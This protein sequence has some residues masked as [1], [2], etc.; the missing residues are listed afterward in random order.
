MKSWKLTLSQLCRIHNN[1]TNDRL[2]NRFFV[3]IFGMIDVQNK[4]VTMMGLGVLG[5]GVNVAKY[6]LEHGVS[7]LIIT[8]LKS[9]EHLNESIESLE[10]FNDRIEYVLERHRLQDFIETDLVVKSPG[11]PI[12]NKYIEAAIKNNVPV[13]MDAS[14]CVSLLPAG[15][16]TIGVTGTKGKSSVTHMLEHVLKVAGKPVFIGGN[17]RGQATLPLLDKINSGDYLVMELDSWQLQGFHDEKISPNIS[18]FTN[19][20][21]DHLNYYQSMSEYYFDKSAI[22]QYQK[23]TDD[24]VL[25]ISSYEALKKYNPEYFRNGRTAIVKSSIMP[26][27]WQV[28]SPGDHNRLNAAQVYQVAKFLNLEDSVIKEGIET[29]KG[30]EGRLQKVMAINNIDFYNDTNATTPEATANSVKS[31]PNKKV[32]LICGGVSKNFPSFKP[33]IDAINK[34]V[35][36]VILFPGG[37]ADAIEASLKVPISKADNM[38]EAVVT[39]YKLSL[40]YADS[41]VIMSPAGS[42]F[43][44]F[45]NEYDRGDQ[46]VEAVKSL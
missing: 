22:Y 6:L 45:K 3:T 39:S 40:K 1:K 38:Q 9:A 13:K 5:R 12:G 44:L 7:K 42:S 24:L 32:I 27:D 19:F 14:W 36:E 29:F 43:G 8:D 21:P 16:T 2:S 11:V 35:T 37:V 46:F 20:M 25:S 41:V 18:V 10:V 33:I 17:I 4:T 34:Y 30:V 15:V 23:K 26:S 31:F 28:Q